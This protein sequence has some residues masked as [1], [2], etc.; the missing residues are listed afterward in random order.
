[1]EGRWSGQGAKEGWKEGWTEGLEKDGGMER[2]GKEWDAG[3]SKTKEGG[4]KRRKKAWMK[5]R[6]GA[7]GTN[8]G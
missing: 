8:E 6:K 7:G 4:S 5:K 1:M 2:W 3:D